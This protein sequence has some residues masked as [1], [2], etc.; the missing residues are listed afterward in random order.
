GLPPGSQPFIE[1]LESAFET[2]GVAEKD[3][4]KVDHL[5]VPKAPPCKAD[6]LIDGSKDPCL[7]S[8]STI[9]ATSPNH[10]GVEGT[11]S[12]SGLDNHRSIGE[13]VHVC[14]AFR[15]VFCSSSSQ[16]HIF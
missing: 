2:S 14:L 5:V 11:D 6:A 12:R 8:C 3:R 10:E 1:G 4:Q 16:R 9:R 7:H 15:K 13:S